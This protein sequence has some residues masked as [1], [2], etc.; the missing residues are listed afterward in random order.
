MDSVALPLEQAIT[1][2]STW[3]TASPY[4]FIL[5]QSLALEGPYLKLCL[6][7]AVN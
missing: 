3:S 2:S 1:I 5:E 6:M 4:T 7:L